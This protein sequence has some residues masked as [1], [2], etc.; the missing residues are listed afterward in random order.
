MRQEQLVIVRR[1][2]PINPVHTPDEEG[3]IKDSF[4]ILKDSALERVALVRKKTQYITGPADLML[5][6]LM[7]RGTNL[8]ELTNIQGTRF[9]G[10]CCEVAAAMSE[11]SGSGFPVIAIN[12]QPECINL[13]SKFDFDGTEIKV[14]T[15]D[16]LHAHVF[17]ED[18]TGDP[19]KKIN[20]LDKVSKN[21]FLDPVGQ[22]AGPI[23]AE[24]MSRKLENLGLSTVK[25]LRDTFPFGASTVVEQNLR[26]LSS[27][28]KLFL[29]LRSVQEDFFTIYERVKS[30]AL[31]KDRSER[32]SSLQRVLGEFK[33]PAGSIRRLSTIAAQ[34]KNYYEVSGYLRFVHGPALTWIIYQQLDG[35]L[36]NLTPRLLSRGNAMEAFGV[37]IDQ[38]S[39]DQKQ[40]LD[41][42]IS[43][44]RKLMLK[45]SYNN[46][47][48]EG[49]VL[50][51]YETTKE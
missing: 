2:V 7:P 8:A 24:I 17:I 21:D 13:P 18:G 30:S 37:W 47:V 34:L 20:E 36:I 4:L 40:S 51:E 50:S 25:L 48:S 11:I 32:G 23:I 38:V 29:F 5:V 46:E 41:R 12:Q 42:Q 19:F 14:Q 45:L 9:F 6:P 15:I 49:E 31:I 10:I 33:L 16:Q 39:T 28:G 3:F 44:F 27:N 22:I 35:V 26:D 43:F 1:E